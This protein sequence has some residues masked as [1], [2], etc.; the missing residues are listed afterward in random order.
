MSVALVTRRGPFTRDAWVLIGRQSAAIAGEN[1]LLIVLP[2]AVLAT[3][4]SP[5]QVG[6]AFVLTR[7]PALLGVS[8]GAIRR[9]L[10]PRT[11]LV[12]CDAG[13]LLCLLAVAVLLAV[14]ARRLFVAYPLFFAIGAFSVLFRATRIE[15]ITHI[16][17]APSLL[18]FNSYDRTVE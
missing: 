18:S 9:R 15:L 14:D 13:R 6:L 7:L 12:V 4:G 1:A 5:L 3:T 16:V 11:L 8:A 10:A 2:L 17:P